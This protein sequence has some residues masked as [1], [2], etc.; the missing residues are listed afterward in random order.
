MTIWQKQP[1]TRTYVGVPASITA[2]KGF[3]NETWFSTTLAG[4]GSDQALNTVKH[5]E[6]VSTLQLLQQTFTWL[7]ETPVE[8]TAPHWSTCDL[9]RE[10]GFLLTEKGFQSKGLRRFVISVRRA[11]SSETG[12]ST[13]P[14][15][16]GC[17][18]ATGRKAQDLSKRSP[19][20]QTTST[21]AFQVD[22][23]Q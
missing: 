17:V 3:K 15:S 5:W 23:H 16:F 10:N 4:A 22:R 19:A 8:S 7:Q 1:N 9:Y 2:S 18:L 13:G 6:E 11:I 20:S 12:K 14:L 21:P